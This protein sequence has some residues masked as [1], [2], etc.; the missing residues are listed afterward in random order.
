ME[1]LTSQACP[2][3]DMHVCVQLLSVFLNRG[4]IDHL[5]ATGSH[6]DPQRRVCL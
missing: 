6:S 5:D 2:Q 4:Q 1:N 3:A